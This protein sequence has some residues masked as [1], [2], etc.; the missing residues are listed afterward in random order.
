MAMSEMPGQVITADSALRALQGC[1][2][3]RPV[4]FLPE[5]PNTGISLTRWRRTESGPSH[6][7]RHPQTFYTLSLILRPMRGRAWAGSA[8]VWSGAVGAN[9]IRLTPPGM[10]P[11]WQSEGEFDFL[12][13]TIPA[14]T[15]DRIAGD[16]APRIHATLRRS[17]PLYGRDEVVLQLARNM[18]EAADS[19]RAFALQFADGLAFSLVAHLLDRYADGPYESRCLGLSP[20]SLRRVRQFISG[21]LAEPLSVENLASVAGLSD[22][23]FAHSF[24]ASTGLPPHQ[25]I[26]AMRIERAQQLL[27]ETEQSI[28]AIAIDCGFKDASHFARVFKTTAGVSPKRFRFHR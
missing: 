1:Y 22:S 12:L 4:A 21:H 5:L 9:T 27:R 17:F 11:S 25:F 28:A 19:E 15:I 16:R 24:R 7:V 8:L 13:F 2:L 14:E 3:A 10:E 26:R 20:H 6:L 18:L 23:H